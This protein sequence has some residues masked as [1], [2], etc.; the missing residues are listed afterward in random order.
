MELKNCNKSK[1]MNSILLYHQN[2]RS[3]TN[4][5]DKLSIHMQTH[6]IDPQFICLTEHHLKVIE[7]NNLSLKGYK[8]ASEF[9]RKKFLGGGVRI[10]INKKL[11]YSAMDLSQYCQEK[12]LEICAVKLNFKSLTLSVP[13]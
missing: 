5:H 11:R 13:N 10:L 12:T 2:I 3:V 6:C 8:L 7:I 4:K 1:S 9:C